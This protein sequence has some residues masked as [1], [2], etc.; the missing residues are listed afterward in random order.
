MLDASDNLNALINQWNG[1]S[2]AT[3]ASPTANNITDAVLSGNSLI[4]DVAY[5]T[6]LQLN[7]AEG[8]VAGTGAVLAVIAAN[9]GYLEAMRH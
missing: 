2:Y 5:M 1:N 7:Q 4:Q 8:A 9:R 3:G 6:A